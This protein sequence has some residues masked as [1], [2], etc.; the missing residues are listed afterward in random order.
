VLALAGD[1]NLTFEHWK[2][3]WKVHGP[4][5]ARD[6]S[7]SSSAL[8]PCYDR[9]HDIALPPCRSF[10]RQSARINEHGRLPADLHLKNAETFK[11]ENP[12]QPE[13]EEEFLILSALS[14]GIG[15][16]PRNPMSLEYADEAKAYLRYKRQT[17]EPD[18][19][20]VVLHAAGLTV[21]ELQKA[22]EWVNNELNCRDVTLNLQL[23]DTTF[24][25]AQCRPTSP[26]PNPAFTIYIGLGCI[27]AFVGIT[28]RILHMQN[29]GALMLEFEMQGRLS[30]FGSVE[31]WHPS[32]NPVGVLS[33]DY[34]SER[35]TSTSTADTALLL[36]FHEIAHALRGHAW[37]KAREGVS[38]EAHARAKESDADWCA[39][40]LFGK[41]EL[42]KLTLANRLNDENLS[43][44]CDRLAVA[45]AS[46][47]CAFQV[48]SDLSSE[49][50]HLP[51]TRTMDNLYGAELAWREFNISASFV[52]F[53]N[54]AY[55]QLTLIDRMLSH[56]LEQ[57]VARDDP[58]NIVD[59][60]EKQTL[61]D[62]I[63]RG[64]HDEALRYERGPI[65]GARTV[66][67]SL[68][69]P[70]TNYRPRSFYR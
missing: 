5:F 28:N 38:V 26:E 50:Y 14:D 21:K 66:W 7:D 23:D 16:G 15:S 10:R 8:I 55:G 53:I 65:K 58:R 47:N 70:K 12:M 40:Y 35:N 51:H 37:I 63:V 4:K 20:H 45:S 68:M 69:H 6:D 11:L 1:P 43:N 9:V 49:L 33:Y 57:W 30:A 27:P 67:E 46:L 31:K 59:K 34:I 24:F 41:H 52:E 17:E 25:F 61:T 29:S 13:N 48:K 56:R 54:K 42:T 19:E 62:S 44:L 32:R 36:F 60:A 3:Y 22:F 2:E 18:A 39:G 64:F